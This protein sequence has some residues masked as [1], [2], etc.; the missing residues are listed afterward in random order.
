M[1]KALGSI[2]STT[3]GKGKKKKEKKTWRTSNLP[4]WAKLEKMGQRG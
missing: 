1:S 2:S 3:K 4:V